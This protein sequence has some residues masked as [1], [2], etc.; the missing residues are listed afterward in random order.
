[1]ISAPLKKL[2][3]KRREPWGLCRFVI[4]G[5]REQYVMLVQLIVISGGSNPKTC[6]PRDAHCSGSDT[7]LKLWRIG[8]ILHDQLQKG[9]K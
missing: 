3:L 9:E 1:M 8:T 4:R 5:W 7:D 2:T 6:D